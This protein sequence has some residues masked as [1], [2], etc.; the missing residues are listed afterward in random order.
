ML[1]N[2]AEISKKDYLLKDFIQ[3][4]SLFYQLMQF[5][6][7]PHTPTVRQIALREH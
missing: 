4:H 1:P 5:F 7:V 2:S 3:L 6:W